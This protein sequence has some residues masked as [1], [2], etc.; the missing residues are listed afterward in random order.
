MQE[1][2]MTG[3]DS[4]KEFT[5]EQKK[6]VEAAENVIVAAGA[7]SG[8]TSVLA[9]RYVHLIIE[10]GLKVEEILTLTFTNKATNEMYARI[11]GF[12]SQKK[13]NE[14]AERAINDFYKTK[15]Q[16]I[17]SFCADIARSG[18]AYYG[19][20][21]DFKSDDAALTALAKE[22]ALSFVLDNREN[23]G[24]Q[25]IIADK[26]I[27]VVA[28]DL[29]ATTVL[30][31]SSISSPLDFD[32]MF[33]MQMEILKEYFNDS[34]IELKKILG[35]VSS[36]MEI[37]LNL[38]TQLKNGNI[39]YK[40]NERKTLENLF[41]VKND[42]DRV[43]KF[44]QDNV[45]PP[46]PDIAKI[47]ACNETEESQKLIALVNF[48]YLF[49]SL[50]ALQHS[51]VTKSFNAKRRELSELFK[52]T[53]SP[54][55]NYFLQINTVKDV[56][57]LLEKFQKEF[58]KKKR[59]TGL[60][61][62][63]DIAHLAV[64]I[65]KNYPD[66]RK[67][68]KNEI[69]AIMID[70]F[71]DNNELQRDLVFL[72][73]EDNKRDKT[74][75]PDKDE[76]STDK[77]FFVGDE[78]Q[79]I[80]RFRGADVSVFKSLDA[81][82]PGLTES[83]NV[84]ELKKNYRSKKVLIDAFNHIFDSVFKP[85]DDQAEAYE[86]RFKALECG[87]TE[88]HGTKQDIQFCILQ[89]NDY[90]ADKKDGIDEFDVESAYIAE[91]IQYLIKSGY[92]VLRRAKAENE[93]VGKDYEE[94]C[95]YGD[96]AILVRRKSQIRNL[97]KQLKKFGVPHCTEDT[98][99]LWK[100]S[101]INDIVSYLRC[102]IY[103]E[104]KQSFATI[105]H[106]A[107][108]RLNDK[109][110]VLCLLNWEKRAFEDADYIEDDKE[111]ERYNKAK[112]NYF[113]FCIQVKSHEMN[114]SDTI[115]KIW[116][117]EGYRFE[118]MSSYSAQKYAEI[119]D[120]FFEI[121]RRFD[122]QKKSIVEFIDE[123]EEKKAGLNLT[124]KLEI[125]IERSGGVKLMTIHKSKGLQF[126]V[127]FVPFCGANPQEKVEQGIVYYK[128]LNMNKI[129][130]FRQTHERNL[131]ML[132]LPV[133]NEIKDKKVKNFFLECFRNDDKKMA[134]AEIKRLLYVVATRAESSLFFTATIPQITDSENKNKQ[135]EDK[136]ESIEKRI[137]IFRDKTEKEMANKKKSGEI[138]LPNFLTLLIFPLVSAYGSLCELEEILAK[139]RKEIHTA[140]VAYRSKRQKNN[141]LNISYR[142]AIEYYGK[143]E[144]E[145]LPIPF[146]EHKALTTLIVDN[147]R[148]KD[149]FCNFSP[150][151]SF[152][153]FLETIGL[154]H[155]EFGEITH[156]VIED[157]LNGINMEIKNEKAIQIHTKIKE[158]ADIFF[159]SE[160]GIKCS[161]AEWYKTEYSFISF[162]VEKNGTQDKKSS[163][164]D[165]KIIIEGRIDLLFK[166]KG[167][168]YIIDFKTDKDINPSLH[169]SQ[170]A[171]YKEAIKNLFPEAINVEAY[172]FYLR[173]DKE[174]LCP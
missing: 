53:I 49:Y 11:Y 74:G 97:E 171:S 172:L 132:N 154:T 35:D 169:K 56:F 83:E 80:Y 140:S 10:K 73:A 166:F 152:D 48:L 101:T 68:Y 76:I 142:N 2:A 119:Y 146:I 31:Y 164:S 64:D 112:E 122:E 167:T 78:K 61:T 165:K 37:L 38:E 66:I 92:K 158:F 117:D 98:V 95:V 16:T 91:K 115:T 6:A 94:P 134:V 159:D 107:F 72:I 8:K 125:P 40:E 105:L 116:Y 130:G 7:G 85:I 143:A 65:L 60:L 81:L 70:E 23:K 148:I 155:S 51:N 100:E 55:S 88:I 139:T 173:H 170:M 36:E 21:S 75:L 131:F 135:Y 71:Q 149:S 79:S 99:A 24:L 163:C 120:Y 118:M 168:I 43:K 19:I 109:N 121:A 153:L 5:G 147:E 4:I 82:I 20:S 86:A 63:N 87:R 160:L 151:D 157:R 110:F 67:I 104:D 41:F 144:V 33:F 47:I 28:K 9:A 59:L 96:F 102:V 156:K 3:K 39:Q 127:V 22:E 150:K 17:D 27:Q 58:N 113:K 34:L 1:S 90:L 137:L 57:K 161:N 44:Y 50:K 77:M 14:R 103:P 111:K 84:I 114:I 126:P 138:M 46:F 128:K 25:K 174:V 129:D 69:K 145:Y 89:K 32:K 136:P 52:K 54:I 106:S 162:L 62:F 26:K 13:E 18:A 15:I 45:C 141:S 124:D 42:F 133:A 93:K 123:I 29:F 12:L 108:V 30:N